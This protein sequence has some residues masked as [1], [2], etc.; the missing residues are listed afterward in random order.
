MT[1]LNSIRGGD[2]QPCL[3]EGSPE[4][5][6]AKFFPRVNEKNLPAHCDRDIS[7]SYDL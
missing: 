5:C 7:S 2:H 4:S 1:R 6:K 3:G